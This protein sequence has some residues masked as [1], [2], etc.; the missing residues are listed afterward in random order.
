[1]RE[2]IESLKHHAG[3]QTLTGN[4]SIRQFVQ[5]VADDAVAHQFAVDPQTALVDFFELIDATQQGALARARGP[6][7]AQDFTLFDFNA[8]VF[9]GVELIVVFV[10]AD[11]FDDVSHVHSPGPDLRTLAGAAGKTQLQP[12]LAERQDRHHCQVP[13]ARDDQ[14]LHDPGV[15]VVDVLRVVQ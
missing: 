10:Q 8:D 12:A 13:D 3:T 5:F 9:E 7:D 2:E 1:M 15:G 4:L 14:Q 11:G 6:D